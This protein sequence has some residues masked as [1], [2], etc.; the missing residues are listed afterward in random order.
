MRD[1]AVAAE[2]EA[3]S[4]N[5]FPSFEDIRTPV[6]AGV[7][8]TEDT[9]VNLPA[10]YK[11]W[12]LNS[13]TIASLPIDV[14]AKRGDT[15][16]SYPEPAWLRRPNDFQT[17]PQFIGMTQVSLDGAGNAYWLKAVDGADRLAG[18]NILAPGAVE[19]AMVTL[20]GKATLVYWLT[21]KTGREMLPANAV[22]HLQSMTMPGELV[23]LSPIACA[24]QTIGIGLA[25]EQFGAQF[26]GT[27]AHPDGVIETAAQLTP[28]QAD[29]LQAQLTKKH[30]GITKAHSLTVLSGGLTWKQISVS[31][32]EAQFLESRRYTA[33]EIANLYGVPVEFV[34]DGSTEG[35]KGY[36]TGV[37]MRFRMWYLTGLMPR[38]K[39]IEDALTALLPRP[40]YVKLNTHALLRMDPAEQTAFFAAGQ[41]GEYI[42]RNEIRSLLDM[43]PLAGGDEMLHSVQWQENAPPPSDDTDDDSEPASAGS[44]VKEEG[45]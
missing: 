12:S 14:Y 23:G 30:G 36:V 35:A 37:S 10:V 28:E 18:L 9:A 40:A 11:C 29:R 5:W 34:G 2:V 38:I 44:P 13:E 19:P 17:M 26:F 1:T 25:A 6:Y 20:D 4:S 7:S 21:T 24:K 39:R 15:R 27:G 31:P 45:Q 33:G 42:S 41:L 3:R 43:N 22:V 8:V 16:V 32:D